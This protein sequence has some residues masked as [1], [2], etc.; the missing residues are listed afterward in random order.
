MRN[1]SWTIACGPEEDKKREAC[2]LQSD[3]RTTKGLCRS[4]KNIFF[5]QLNSRSLSSTSAKEELDKHMNDFY[6]SVNCIQ[7]HRQVHIQEAPPI[8][9][10][11]IGSGCRCSQP[12]RHVKDKVQQLGRW[13][14]SEMCTAP[15]PCVSHQVKGNL[16]THVISCYSPKNVSNEKDVVEFYLPPPACLVIGGDFNAQVSNGFSYHSNTNRNGQLLLDFIQP[17]DDQQS[18]VNQNQYSGLSEHRINSNLK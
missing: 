16:N 8:K 2:I 10:T 9:A 13:C 3:A 15:E 7:E 4:K 1:A 6:I 5:G 12:P 14:S 17:S 18:S 11:R